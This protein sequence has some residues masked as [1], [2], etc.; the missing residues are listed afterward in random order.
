MM[1]K[2]EARKWAHDASRL[3]E[4]ID[5]TR[6]QAVEEALSVVDH[7]LDNA[8]S[9]ETRKN[10]LLIRGEILILHTNLLRE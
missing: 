2:D 9:P 7:T 10:L 6:I 5:M 1:T 4:R 8:K 3:L